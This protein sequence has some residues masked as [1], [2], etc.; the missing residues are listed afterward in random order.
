MPKRRFDLAF[1]E[2]I[3]LRYERYS[4]GTVSFVKDLL[5]GERT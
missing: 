5:F 4:A 3:T 1:K 2:L